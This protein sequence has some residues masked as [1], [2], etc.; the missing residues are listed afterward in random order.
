MLKTFTTLSLQLNAPLN[1][2]FKLGNKK[3]NKYKC[4]YKK[5]RLYY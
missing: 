1:K 2:F 5:E 4:L 3:W